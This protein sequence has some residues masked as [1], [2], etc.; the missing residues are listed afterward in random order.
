MRACPPVVGGAKVVCYT[1][2]DHRHRHTGNAKQIVGG[3]LLASAAGLAICNY[4]GE[5]C[6][7]LFGCDA[8]WNSRSDSWHQALEDATVQAELEYEGTMNT[9]VA[10]QHPK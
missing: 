5:D 10:F 8:D 7:Y 2:I 6:F 9:W 4:D 3:V 1:P